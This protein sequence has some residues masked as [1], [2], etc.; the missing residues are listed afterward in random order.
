M[1]Q[2]N[3]Q[4]KFNRRSRTKSTKE[5]LV[6]KKRQGPKR[7]LPQ[8]DLI[9]CS[10]QTTEFLPVKSAGQP[11]VSGRVNNT[12]PSREGGY[13]A[14]CVSTSSLASAPKPPSYTFLAPAAL[15]L[16]TKTQHSK[17]GSLYNQGY[18]WTRQKSYRNSNWKRPFMFSL[19]PTPKSSLY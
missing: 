2:D 3:R 6:C 14:L 5:I 15:P 7:A 18:M 12:L 16:S 11:P 19:S 4:T 1:A 13:S 8:P 9:S 17:S 10:G